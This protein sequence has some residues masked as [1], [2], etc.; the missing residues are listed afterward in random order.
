MFLKSTSVGKNLQKHRRSKFIF[1]NVAVKIIYLV[2]TNIKLHH[3][4]FSRGLKILKTDVFLETIML[5][6]LI[7]TENNLQD[8]LVEVQNILMFYYHIGKYGHFAIQ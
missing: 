2:K 5:K 8:L 6:R 1:S 3:R 7:S 4:C